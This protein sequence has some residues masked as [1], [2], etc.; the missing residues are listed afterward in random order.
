METLHNFPTL[1]KFWCKNH[2][3]PSFEI[4]HFTRMI[5]KARRRI[6]WRSMIAICEM[7]DKWSWSIVSMTAAVRHSYVLN[8][9]WKMAT[10]QQ[11]NAVHETFL[12]MLEIAY[13]TRRERRSCDLHVIWRVTEI[14]TRER[15]AFILVDREQARSH[16][17]IWYVCV[18]CDSSDDK[19]FRIFGPLPL[20]HAFTAQVR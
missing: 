13:L 9:M 8:L 18:C 20:K 5:K 11:G 19:C 15:Q 16:S 10:W 3:S 2:D 4:R 6:K 14:T 1:F 12:L 17:S 7:D